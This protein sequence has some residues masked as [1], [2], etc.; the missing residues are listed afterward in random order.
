MRLSFII[1]V[2][3]K[4]ELTL[5]VLKDLSYL[6]YDNHEIIIVDNHPGNETEK[7]LAALD[8]KNL[9]YLRNGINSF[10]LA[11]NKGYENSIGENICFLNNDIRITKNKD[12][13]TD[14]I[15]DEIEKNDHCIIG[16]YGGYIDNNFNFKYETYDKN[17]KINYIG[18]CCLIGSRNTFKTIK[19]NNN[20]EVF[21][22]DFKFY[23]EDTYLSTIAARNN[24]KLKLVELPVYH[25]GQGS[26]DKRKMNETYI[27]SREVF[28]RK[29]KELNG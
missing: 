9:K 19:E 28:I 15:F 13:W 29:V 22:T 1:P 11:C 17:K 6:S 27:K 24:I 2:Y 26:T 25:I 7:A 5:S 4:L 18:G 12:N 20:D 16:P 23:F 10:S 21:S 14:L 3:G 8:L